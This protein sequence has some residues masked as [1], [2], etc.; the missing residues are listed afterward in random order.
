MYDQT[1]RPQE[2]KD[3]QNDSA[4]Y[5]LKIKP[6]SWVCQLPLDIL[7][8]RP[9]TQHKQEKRQEIQQTRKYNDC[10]KKAL[11]MTKLWVI[12]MLHFK[13]KQIVI[14]CKKA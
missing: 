8:R 2:P 12:K 13:L 7:P 14:L 5:E 9:A 6:R 10:G 4:C 1:W 3:K 11:T